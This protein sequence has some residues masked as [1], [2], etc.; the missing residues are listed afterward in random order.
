MARRRNSFLDEL[1][2]GFGLGMQVGKAFEQKQIGEELAAADS[3]GRVRDS[4]VDS[5][6]EYQDAAKGLDAVAFDSPEQKAAAEKAY[7]DAAAGFKGRYAVGD[8]GFSD[9]AEA[10]SYGLGLSTQKMADVYRQHGQ[11]E[12][13]NGLQKD[14]D[15]MQARATQNKLAGLQLSRAQREDDALL[16]FEKDVQD[17]VSFVAGKFGE[18]LKQQGIALKHQMHPNGGVIAWGEDKDGNQV[19][20]AAYYTME[21]VRQEAFDRYINSTNPV[22]GAEMATQAKNR[23]EDQEYRQSRDQVTDRRADEQ[24]NLSRAAS[25]RAS[26]SHAMAV[27]DQQRKAELEAAVVGLRKQLS[28]TNDPAQRE[29]IKQQIED[30]A[31]LS[32]SQNLAPRI[33]TGEDGVTR[34]IF[35]DGTQAPVE[36]LPVRRPRQQAA[37]Q[38]PKT[39]EEADAY[40]PSYQSKFKSKEEF[41]QALGL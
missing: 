20:P 37:G 36:Q 9:Q 10:N 21:Q 28:E 24:L 17:P 27:A 35:P 6:Q 8:K 23:K 4:Q 38:R 15:A 34:A 41:Y 1:A 19:M 2:S 12:K 25:G 31:G 16:R 26:E 39:R 22:K 7:A 3:A 33:A 18:E 32:R 40:W 14:Y 30:L 13:A 29:A 5:A 11:I